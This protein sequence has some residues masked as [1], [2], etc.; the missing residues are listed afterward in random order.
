[1]ASYP[2]ELRCTDGE[3]LR[4]FSQTNK[5]TQIG[6]LSIL[7][8]TDVLTYIVETPASIADPNVNA[9]ESYEYSTLYSTR[10]KRDTYN[11]V[12]QSRTKRE[13]QALCIVHLRCR[14]D[15]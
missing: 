5:A 10:R 8:D 13:S 1:M 15:V 11:I 14:Q 12:N 6:K 3:N 4:V 9:T 2:K 7:D